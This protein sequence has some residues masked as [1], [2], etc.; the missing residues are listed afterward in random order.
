MATLNSAW[1]IATGTLE[2][3]QA[4]LNVTA[5]NTANVNT[6]GY[7]RETAVWEED[8]PV[9]I[10]NVSYGSGASVAQVSSQRD[11]VLE[12]SIDQQTQVQQATSTR[13]T[14][15]DNVQALFADATSSNSSTSGGISAALNGFFDS[16]SSL[17][18]NPS[19]SSLREGVL[20]A[21]GSLAGSFA[22]A[23]GG[24]RQQQAALDA[25][26]QSVV[27]QVN[28]LTSAIAALN[29]QIE[30]EDP[31]TDAGALEDQR[32][33]DLNQLSQLIG[34]HQIQT[35]SNGLTITT[36]AGAL[37]VSQNESFAIGSG[38]IDGVT[39][40]F[41]YQ[42]N[43]ITAALASGGGQIGGLLTV[44]DQD[45]PQVENALDAL[46]GQLATQV[47]SIQE[48]GATETGSSASGIPLFNV[49]ASGGAP[50]GV[51]GGITVAITDP[52]Q[53]AA[54]AVGNGPSDG[55]NAAAMADLQNSGVVTLSQSGSPYQT[56][57]ATAPST[58]YS[59]FVAALG[60][61]VSQTSTLS[62]AQQA[63]LTQMQTQRNTLSAVNEDDEAS[64]LALLERSYEA[65]SKVF[66]ILDSIFA[67]AL[68]LG[69]EATVA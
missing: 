52:S 9:T 54:A 6:P 27:S 69:E 51:A 36:A 21:A 38:P 47:N 4:A 14:A 32:Q 62:T 16:L 18:G 64:S 3:D 23:I 25:E 41:D 66:T 34:I 44:R 12:Q 20:S 13:L 10:G 58:F 26:S 59:N 43:D 24:L 45:I 11:R 56:N 49:P 7:T 68:N 17:E 15:L 40:Y 60:S 19:D 33:Y 39:H 31:A 65:A 61:L 22:T 55:S 53:L 50:G 48:S 1:N 57:T 2:A 8:A 5:N 29:Q 35:E 42:R 37:L 30:S 67:S 46:A 63:S 28:S